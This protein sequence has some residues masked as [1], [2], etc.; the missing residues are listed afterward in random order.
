MPQFNHPTDE[1]G[2]EFGVS[3]SPGTS[4]SVADIAAL[5]DWVVDLG[6]LEVTQSFR[7][8][9][10][11]QLTDQVS[12]AARAG[13]IAGPAVDGPAPLSGH[14]LVSFDGVEI[15]YASRGLDAIA[16]RVATAPVDAT[17]LVLSG[18]QLA[19][20]D[21]VET[22]LA[23]GTLG[24]SALMR[25]ADGEVIAFDEFGATSVR[26]LISS[27]GASI[28]LNGD[29]TDDAAIAAFTGTLSANG[30]FDIVVDYSGPSQ[31]QAAF[32]T[33]AAR[34]AQ[35]IVG[36]I[37]DVNDATYGFIDD[38]LI[39]ASIVAIDGAGGILG[40]AGPDW[41]RVPSYLP[42][43]GTMQFDTADVAN[44]YAGGTW[45]N[46]ILH[47]MGHVLGIGT[48]WEYMGLKASGSFNYTGANALAEY[49]LV[50]GQPGATVVPLETGGGPGTAGG[51]WSEAVFDAELMTGYVEASGVSMPLSTVTVG[52]LHDMGYT[53][54]YNAADTFVLPGGTPRPGGG[55]GGPGSLT[56]SDVTVTEGDS[57]TKVAA[58]TVTRSGGSGI[59]SVNYATAN[60]TATAGSDYVAASGT[61]NF[62]TNQTTATINVTING[63][64][65]SEG[66]ETF[67]VNLSNATAGATISDSQGL[68][69]IT[70]DDGAALPDLTITAASLDDTTLDSG[71]TVTVSF[72]VANI[73]AAASGD[74][75][76][77]YYISTD[78]II[79][80]GDTFIGYNTLSS[81]AAGANA[82]YN[83]NFSAPSLTPGATYYFGVLADDLSVL[84]ESNESNNASSPIAVTYNS[85][86]PGSISIADVSITEGDAGTKVATFTVT[87]SGGTA[88][89]N[90]NYAT[91]NGTATA[92]S[93]YVATSGTLAFGQNINT[94]TVSVTINGD[95][96]FEPNETFFVNLSGGTN[97][98]TISDSQAQGTITNDDAEPVGSIS[99]ADVSITE[100]DAG[101]KVATFTVT[102]SGGTAA[103]AVNY[104]TANHSAVSTSDY[105]ATSGTLNFGQGVDTQTISVTINGDTTY[106][107]DEAFFVNLSGGTNGVTISDGAAFGTILNDD[108][109][110]VGSIS[111]ADVAITE[112]NS[113]TKVA[114]FTVTRTGGTAAFAVDYATSDGTATAGSDYVAK[115]GTLNF[116]QFATAVTVAVT[117]NGDLTIEGNETFF[118]DLTNAT[119]GVVVADSQAKG[120]ITN[121]DLVGSVAIGDVNVVE[122]DSGTVTMTFTVTRSGGAAPFSVD[123]ATADFSATSPS[124]YTATSGTLSFAQGQNTATFTVNANGDTVVEGREIFLVNLS[125]ITNGGILADGQ[126]LGSISNDD[127]V[128]ATAPFTPN[129]DALVVPSTGGTWHAGAGDDRPVGT[130]GS[131]VIY[132]D[133]GND[134]LDGRGGADTLDGGD[135]NDALIFDAT[136]TLFGGDGNDYAAVGGSAGVAMSFTPAQSIETVIGGSGN[137]VFDASAMNSGITLQGR[138]GADHLIGGSAGDLLVG[139]ADSDV[140]TLDG[141]SGNDTLSFRT[142]DILIGGAGNDTASADDPVGA[143]ISIVLAVG[144][145]IETILGAAGNDVIDASAS[146]TRVLLEGRGGA[147]LLI[148]GA[149]GDLL[150]FDAGDQLIGGG[151]NDIATAVDPAKTGTSMFILSGVET[152]YGGG[153]ADIIDAS[154]TTAANLDTRLNVFAGAGS[155]VVTGGSANDSLYGGADADT[156]DGGAGDD[157]LFFTTG[158]TLIGGEGNDNAYAEE[159]TGA[160][161]VLGAA[162]GIEG[163]FGHVGGDTLDASAMTTRVFMDGRGGNDTVVGGSG[164]D[165]MFGGSGN[166]VLTGN[167]GGD[168]FM[169]DDNWGQDIVT[170]FQDGVDRFDLSRVEGLESFT[171]LAF[172]QTGADVVIAIGNSSNNIT[173]QNALVAEFTSADFFL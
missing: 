27:S 95:T 126:A 71:Q 139:G 160:S 145:G 66:N 158:D 9:I 106:E 151:G 67:F 127:S 44:M 78:N 112:G 103:F 130:S 84:T 101:T 156:L 168:F 41:V 150:Y 55:G 163:L 146:T 86:N 6:A 12:A 92:G 162:S 64:T 144:H 154:A 30:Q 68:G 170:D 98:I 15:I 117:I 90:V 57:G 34:W 52:S 29:E 136:D 24:Q 53:V 172:T 143:G 60:G 61:L 173:V 88:A 141:G 140:D 51:H 45:T 167:G 31:Y 122:G 129:D 165:L 54:D 3:T 49:R 73:G 123:Y 108:A 69:T 107:Q 120:T 16:V 153:G 113:G 142:G 37:P 131:D 166:D 97:G 83:V 14:Q 91:A 135:G 115:S 65:T 93:D 128:A 152:V 32:S 171:Q 47:E 50:S 11:S 110:P 17:P 5:R 96:T 133:T 62:S 159:I 42:Y 13:A 100:G 82:T 102:R 1:Q 48:L 75:D 74:F 70:N 77:G 38:L 56:I 124:D 85:A 119:N 72:T 94:Q 147:D 59:F 8:A 105:V 116:S 114:T 157:T 109:E 121:D 58:F 148:G 46:V 63:D 76:V 4:M 132:G 21:G 87:R 18:D 80:S 134:I 79:T 161:V 23:D 35:V 39:D 22:I 155:D 89:F 28:V 40:Q 2:S 99:I 125:G 43:H 26:M 111:I 138:L 137:D 20:F 33:A 25:D 118:L 36:D 7:S 10:I 81:L 104:A 164:S 149:L 169:F 19:Y